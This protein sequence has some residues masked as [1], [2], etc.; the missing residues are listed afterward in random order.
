MASE[1]EVTFSAAETATSR[2]A[3]RGVGGKLKRQTARRH[4][5]TPYSRAPQNQVQRRP[6]ISRIVDPAYRIISGGATRLL[7]YFFSNAAS[8]PALTAPNDQDQHQ[9]FF[10]LSS[11]YLASYKDSLPGIFYSFVGLITLPDLCG[12]ISVICSPWV[13][14]YLGFC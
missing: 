2:E 12:C 9:G 11:L 8:A 10:A 14:E 3:A 13:Y 6:W 4:P 7:P 5:A 1:G